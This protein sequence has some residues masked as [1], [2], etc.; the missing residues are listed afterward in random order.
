MYFDNKFFL[1]VNKNF[2][3]KLLVITIITINTKILITIAILKFQS[4]LLVIVMLML[5]QRL[6]VA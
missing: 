5:R 1:I 3:L 6:C 2:C 4:K